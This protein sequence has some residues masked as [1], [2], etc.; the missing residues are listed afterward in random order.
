MVMLVEYCTLIWSRQPLNVR[1]PETQPLTTLKNPTSVLLAPKL[2]DRFDPSI[3]RFCTP[4][5]L[6]GVV[7]HAAWGLRELDQ[8]FST[9]GG[10]IVTATFVPEQDV[11]IVV[12]PLQPVTT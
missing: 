8:L 10:L 5:F 12:E 6:S 1:I 3:A 7:A 11:P 4:T 9:S 2:Q